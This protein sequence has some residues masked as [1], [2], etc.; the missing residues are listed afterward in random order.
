MY[1][2][3]FNVLLP[4]LSLSDDDDQTSKNG[5][6]SESETLPRLEV[7]KLLKVGFKT[8][9]LLPKLILDEM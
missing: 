1:L 7:S 9:E 4:R 2:Y 6:D 8:K 3:Y 5:S